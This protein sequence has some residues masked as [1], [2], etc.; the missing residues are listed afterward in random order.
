M[1][2]WIYNRKLTEKYV[3]Y[4]ADE[5]SRQKKI[6]CGELVTQGWM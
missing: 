4:L 6:V 5:L 2:P 1:V 3:A